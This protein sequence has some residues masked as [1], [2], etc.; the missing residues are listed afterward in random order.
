MFISVPVSGLC[1]VSSCHSE[2]VLLAGTLQKWCESRLPDL[3]A[4]CV[5]LPP[6]GDTS[7]HPLVKVGPIAGLHSELTLCPF[8]FHKNFLERFH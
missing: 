7:V 2:P 6:L 3:E 4:H 1:G 5:D 8:V